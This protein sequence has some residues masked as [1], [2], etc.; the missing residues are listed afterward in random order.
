MANVD[1]PS[2]LC[3]RSVTMLSHPFPPTPAPHRPAPGAFDPTVSGAVVT[4]NA[5]FKRKEGQNR[6][7]LAVVVAGSPL[8]T[9]QPGSQ[10]VQGPRS[11]VSSPG[12]R[13]EVS[14]RSWW[15]VVCTLKWPS[16][17]CSSLC[18]A[19]LSWCT[20]PHVFFCVCLLLLII[21]IAFVRVLCFVFLFSFS[22]A[23]PLRQATHDTSP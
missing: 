14:T 13:K 23:L 10:L 20:A 7:G 18:G 11:P 16:L 15:V 1:A 17:C 21:A 22:H 6:P 9:P 8:F 5:A 12:L 19:F 2:T 3:P 4:V